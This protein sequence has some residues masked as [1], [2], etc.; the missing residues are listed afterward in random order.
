MIGLVVN[1]VAGV[2]GPAGLAGSD[3]AAVQVGAGMTAYANSNGF[4][5]TERGTHHSLSVALINGIIDK[6]RHPLE[7]K[8]VGEELLKRLK[9][10]PGS[11]LLRDRSSNSPA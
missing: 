7:T 10:R 3:G 4:I 2:G 8:T 9:V 6:Y 11:N 5:G 1:P